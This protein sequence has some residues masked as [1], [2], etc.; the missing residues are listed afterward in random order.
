MQSRDD[1]YINTGSL[2]RWL[3]DDLIPYL[4]LQFGQ[5]PR[6]KGQPILLVAMQGN[7]VQPRID[8]L[9][10]LIRD[11]INDALLKKSGKHP[12]ELIDMVSS[13]GG[14]TVEGIKALEKA[15]VRSAI[16]DAVMQA[17]RRARELS[18]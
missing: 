9:T 16:N 4:L 1:S 14:T 7:N 15:E 11:K 10:D 2:D 3:E 18:E 8:D 12:S 17:F 13:P 6:F 5:H